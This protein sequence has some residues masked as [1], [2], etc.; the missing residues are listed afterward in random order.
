ME[1]GSQVRLGSADD[2]G[3]LPLILLLD[4]LQ[5]NDSCGLLVHHC[6]KTSLALNDNVGDTHLTTERR[7]EDDELDG[8]D[9]VGDD[10]E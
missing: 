6:A 3:K 1:Q 8:V 10:D 5:S 9:V 2:G 7:E 4:V